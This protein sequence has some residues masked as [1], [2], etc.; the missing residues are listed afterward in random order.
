MSFDS[1]YRK[2]DV[3]TYNPGMALVEGQKATAN[4]FKDA[5]NQ[6]DSLLQDTEKRY[7]EEN[8]LNAQNELQK[9]I[10]SAG[11]SADAPDLLEFKNKFGR[12]IRM[13][14]L[15]KTIASERGKLVS[16]A[17]DAASLVALDTL[18]KTRDITA[19]GAA[20]RQS[21]INAG[22]KPEQAGAAETA[23][24]QGNAFRG[25]DIAKQDDRAMAESL[26][27]SLGMYRQAG[28]QV[29]PGEID[30]EIAKDLPEYLRG[31]FQAEAKKLRENEGKLSQTQEDELK[32]IDQNF[33]SM[34]QAA[35]VEGQNKIS[36]AKAAV[37]K[38]GWLP[39]GAYNG[40]SE[41]VAKFGGVGSEAAEDLNGRWLAFGMRDLEGEKATQIIYDTRD[42]LLNQG[43]PQKDVDAVLHQAYSEARRGSDGN[44]SLDGLA[45]SKAAENYASRYGQYAAA[46]ANYNNI[47][48]AEQQRLLAL[49]KEH[50]DTIFGYRQKLQEGN[51]L[52]ESRSAADD[53]KQKLS[54]QKDNNAQVPIENRDPIVVGKHN[55][56]AWTPDAGYKELVTKIQTQ[57]PK[58][59][60][61]A[62]YD[63]YIKKN[64][65]DSPI[66]GDMVMAAAAKYGSDP[67]AIMTVM[68]ADS[69]FGTAGIA[70][71]TKNPGNIGTLS[72]KKEKSYDSWEQG[73]EEISRLLATDRYQ[74][75]GG[76]TGSAEITF[77]DVIKKAGQNTPPAA[78]TKAVAAIPATPVQPQQAPQAGNQPKG[79]FFQ[80]PE[81][82]KEWEWFTNKLRSVGNK[83]E[84][85]R[86]TSEGFA[87]NFSKLSAADQ[88]KKIEEIAEYDPKM[89]DLVRNILKSK[90]S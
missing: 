4:A 34:K 72:G 33:L 62:T 75:K 79:L 50:A 15:D 67:A 41:F 11:L 32:Y 16:Q 30:A 3:S 40:A 5:L 9:R 44:Y 51:V 47:S 69:S 61:A 54:G 39:E 68:Q 13:E 78:P 73:V 19:A 65:P 71:R 21:L 46:V 22:M 90:K 57:L 38:A 81:A 74:N 23:W 85:N 45:F 76:A 25:E 58:Q 87:K 60:S 70:K 37:D 28:G 36:T 24:R 7:I 35:Q 52:G 18:D 43:I 8:T 63:A 14:D 84:V 66:T 48:N 80:S 86:L 53:F 55:L 26:D 82:A 64:F 27:T 1:A 12:H 77:A 10:R 49:D 42:K 59:A 56:A 89:A 17:T 29:T 31:R 83:D 88:E 6:I 20:F 2:Y